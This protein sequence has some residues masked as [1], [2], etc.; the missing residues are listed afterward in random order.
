M[1]HV[2]V[3]END[4]ATDE[5]VM[6]AVADV[7]KLFRE[8]AECEAEDGCFLPASYSRDLR[9]SLQNL[10]DHFQAAISLDDS[11]SRLL[12]V[13]AQT[14][15]LASDVEGLQTDREALREMLNDIL[16][17]VEVGQ[18]LTPIWTRIERGFAQFT[19]SLVRHLARRRALNEMAF[20]EE[21]GVPLANWG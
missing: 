8:M 3:A 4:R 13:V 11:E 5:R 1:D 16:E 9:K 14:A 20:R 10:V 12:W 17:M 15:Q 19:R 7:A 21:F 18:S 2:P 6:S